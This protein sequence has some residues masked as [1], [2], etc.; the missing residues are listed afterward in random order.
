MNLPALILAVLAVI[1]FVCAYLAVAR[2][3]ANMAL[4]LALLA[5]AW[6]VQL[7]FVGLHQYSVH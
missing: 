4:G 5:A 7:I 3:W 2:K 1:V 6:V